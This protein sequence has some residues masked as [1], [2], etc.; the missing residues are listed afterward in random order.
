[1]DETLIFPLEL[2]YY[3]HAVKLHEQ[4]WTIR[5]YQWLIILISHCYKG[6]NKNIKY[7]I[8]IDFNSNATFYC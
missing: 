5:V 7:N 1:M 2:W 6:G 3:F 8:I 4:F